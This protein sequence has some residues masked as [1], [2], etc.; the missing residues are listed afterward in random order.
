MASCGNRST[1]DKSKSYFR[2]PK[3]VTH[4]GD[5]TFELS[6]RRRDEWLARIRREDITPKQHPD[7][8]VCSD[9]FIGGPAAKL[10]DVDNTD[11]APSLN[12]GYSSC[13]STSISIERYKRISKRN[14][15]KRSRVDDG[16]DIIVNRSE[17]VDDN[18]G[19]T[20]VSIADNEVEGEG[21]KEISESDDLDNVVQTDLTSTCISKLEENIV[22]LDSKNKSISTEAEKAHE[23]MVRE[24]KERENFLK[25]EVARLKKEVDNLV[26][27]EER[28][29]DNDEKI[30]FFTGLS[31]W[32]LF[33]VLFQLIKL[34]LKQYSVLTP[35]QQLMITMMRLRLGLS[36]QDL[37][38]RFRVSSATIRRT[39]AHVIDVLY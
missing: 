16:A 38:Y 19:D 21:E 25:K 2:L 26:Y 15:R 34:K 39:F 28:F 37:A 4:Q 7:I 3:V 11:W 6:K 9:H 32:E 24:N 1:R 18:E 22:S 13:H 29:K 8:C 17:V 23:K 33:H 31:T 12:L 10:Y 36:G 35:F 30:V 5:K 14:S 27:I 20:T